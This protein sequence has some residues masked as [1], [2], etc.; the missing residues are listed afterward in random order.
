MK[1][2]FSS[3]CIVSLSLACL[4]AGMAL[5]WMNLAPA[6]AADT[7]NETIRVGSKKFTESVI[8]GEIV[9]QLLQSSN[10]PG[11]RHPVLHRAELGGTRILWSALQSGDLDLYPE[12]TGTLTE[13]LL[14]KGVAN[15]EDA[16]RSALKAQSIGMTRSLGFN[17]TYAVGMKK[18]L[19]KRLSIRTLTDLKTHPELKLGLSSEFKQRPDGWPAVQ[20]RYALPQRNIKALDH[21]VAYRALE[22][23]E[24]DLVDLYSTD[25]EIDYYQLLVLEDDLKVFPRYESVLIYRLDLLQ[26]APEVG[27][28]LTK[29]EGSISETEMISL[30][31]DAK[32][33]HIP[34]AKVAQDF[35][36]AHF[37]I[38]RTQATESVAFQILE[39][40]REH[41]G[42][43]LKSMFFS[44]LVALPLGIWASRR[45]WSG[46]VILTTVG[47]IQTIP[48][49]ALL[50]MLIRPLKAL[51]F[52][53]I[54]D[55][56]AVVALFLYS[57]LPMVR[58]T[59]SGLSG[60]SQQIRES[61]EVLGMKSFA[62][63]RLIELPLASSFILAG[64]KTAVVINIGFATLGALVGAGGFGQPILTGI[65]LDDHSLI[66]QGAVPAALLALAAQGFF[67]VLER[68]IVP[69][70]LKLK[71]RA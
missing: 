66:L 68:W 21:E 28:F 18:S 62:R 57:L 17:N 60:I 61:A 22:S 23:D 16:I 9:R 30:N 70:G 27:A 52:Q 55:T 46:Q 40:L 1:K 5:D 36:N 45:P 41:L 24:I 69:R 11:Q 31:A 64:I 39:R 58:N 63:L 3:L 25:A 13:E 34:E 29:L 56:P 8:L 2:I 44:I 12:Y 35:L 67:E 53:G 50:V 32:I 19:A 4:P 33:R 20:K 71:S 6:F 42:L 54:G 59:H 14:P 15:S 51:G 26:R 38:Q 7:S 37:G 43:V 47:I 65:R 48:A 49:L 10:E